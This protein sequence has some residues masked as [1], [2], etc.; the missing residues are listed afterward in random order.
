MIIS[1]LIKELEDYIENHGDVEV[2]VRAEGVGES[3]IKGIFKLNISP[4]FSQCIIDATE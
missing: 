3:E 2:E 1:E 4:D